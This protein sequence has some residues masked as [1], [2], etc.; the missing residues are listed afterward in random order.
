MLPVLEQPR[1]LYLQ[2][3]LVYL[4]FV[5]AMALLQVLVGV[6]AGR[7]RQGSGM[8]DLVELTS[9][10]DDYLLQ[11]LSFEE[12]R[13]G[14]AGT[15]V[16]HS[17]RLVNHRVGGAEWQWVEA[18]HEYTPTTAGA[19]ED[20]E[21]LAA[22]LKAE[23][24]KGGGESVRKDLD[25]REG[26]AVLDLVFEL[27][28]AHGRD[29]ATVAVSRITVIRRVTP[30]TGRQPAREEKVPAVRPPFDVE[31]PEDE[32]SRP[33]RPRICI[34]ID[35]VGDAPP[36]EAERFWKLSGALTFAVLPY[37]QFTK[38]QAE[39]ASE[40]GHEVI[41]HL[42]MEPL[43][44]ENPGVGAVLTTLDDTTVV[45]RVAD[46]LAAVPQAVGLNNHMG[47]RASGDPRV[48]RLIL[49][50]VHRRGLF[51]LDSMSIANSVGAGLAQEMGVP[52]ARRHV[53]L[54]NVATVEA[55]TA[56]LKLLVRKAKA[57]GLAIGI[58]H[59]NRP[60]TAQALAL[61]LPKL[62]TMG[63]DLVPLSQVVK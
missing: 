41:L 13:P 37:R 46:A 19:L 12:R 32:P 52:S 55:V 51:F 43:G 2:A 25:V 33:G 11:S 56:Q 16:K 63:V 50:E 21:Q 62:K 60:A 3:G 35:D 31:P 26:R 36:V 40:L 22:D 7:S 47:S 4:V 24:L 48:M 57:S 18:R 61:F 20:L 58:G 23:W 49:G 54:D 28:P 44:T 39:R 27:R 17:Y 59:L 30:V 53:F 34:V 10:M 42:P 45:E 1:R 38:E 6:P 29:P 8:I 5:A 9:A 14:Q 15:P